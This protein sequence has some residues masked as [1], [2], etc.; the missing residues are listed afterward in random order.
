MGAELSVGRPAPEIQTRL[1]DSQE[2]FQLSQKRG[3]TIIVNLWATWCGP[4]KAEMPAIQAYLDKHKSQGLEVLAISMDDARDEAAV[5][6]IARQYSFKF[7]LKSDADIKGLGRI[8]R[9]PTTFVIDKNGVLQKNGHL[10]DAE[11]G[12]SELETLVTPLLDNP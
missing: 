5:R 8:W 1:L 11:I 12:I 6:N 7:A 10:G 4:C 3:Q 9:L 2:V